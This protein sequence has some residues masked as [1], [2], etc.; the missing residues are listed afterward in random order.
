MPLTDPT[1]PHQPVIYN[2]GGDSGHSM[3]TCNCRKRAGLGP[4]ARV[5]E[6]SDTIKFYNDPDR[7]VEPFGKEDELRGQ[8]SQ[9]IF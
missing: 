5:P 3:L 8:R 6:F 7:H 4:I 1:L 9:G 2:P